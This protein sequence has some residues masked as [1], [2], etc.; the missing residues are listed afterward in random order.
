MALA[1]SAMMSRYVLAGSGGLSAGKP[2]SNFNGVQIGAITYSYRGM[3]G[4]AEELLK[5]IVKCGLNSVELMG[6]PAE[7]F[8]GVPTG[9]GRPGRRGQMT[10]EQ[11]KARQQRQEE[12]LNWR[13]SVS[14][15]KYRALR[16][17]YND[18]GVNIHIVKFGSIGNPGMTD[19][20]IDYY[21]N[22][23]RALG[24]KGITRELSEEAARR[25][26]PIADKHKIMNGFHNH[27]QLTDS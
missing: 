14:M 15:D 5:Y 13:L 7:Q 22:V 4:T 18:A 25:L 26:G 1:A 17:L 10:E 16:K 27:T 19:G 9:G 11:R 23:A 20:E 8:A 3:P 6:E 24:A 21:F 2:N 12:Q